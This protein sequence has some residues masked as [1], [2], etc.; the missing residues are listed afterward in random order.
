VSYHIV[1]IDSPECSLS[2][3]DGQLTCKTDAG[4]RKLPL[5][6]IAAII[7]TSFSASIH[8]QLLLEAAKHGIRLILRENFKPTSPETSAKIGQNGLSHKKI[9]L[10][11]GTC[12]PG[13]PRHHKETPSASSEAR[14]RLSRGRSID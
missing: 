6:D 8:S 4:E 14:R 5:E 12:I 3:R 7:I 9:G 1:N 2:C 13:C 10:T 11:Q